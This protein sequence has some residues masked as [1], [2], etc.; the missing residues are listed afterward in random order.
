MA[1]SDRQPSLRGLTPDWD[2]QIFLQAQSMASEKIVSIF[3]TFV[4]RKFYSILDT[5]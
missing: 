1:D 4:Y 5:Y 2:L 3:V